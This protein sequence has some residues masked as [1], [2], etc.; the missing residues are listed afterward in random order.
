MTVYY[1]LYGVLLVTGLII[2]RKENKIELQKIK[3]RN[4]TIFACILLIALFALR[5]P[6]MGNDLG[7]G[8][9]YGYLGQFKYISEKS[10]ISVFTE[11]FLQYER[12]YI[13]LNKLIGIFTVDN[14]IFLLVIT[15]IALIPIFYYIYKNS[16]DVVLSTIIFMG[17]PVFEMYFSG[18]RQVIAIGIVALSIKYIE[19]KKLS[20]FILIIFIASLFHSSAWIFLIAYPIFYIKSTDLVKTFSTLALPIIYVLRY[21]LFEIFS[22]LFRENATP[23]DNGA[24][25]LFLVFTAVYIFLLI[26]SDENDT[27]QVGLRNLFWVACACQAF[28]GVYSIAMRVGYYFMMSLPILL[29]RV[30]AFQKKKSEIDKERDSSY[31][32]MYIIIFAA[33]VIFGLYTLK[34]GTWS[35][36]FPYYFY[37]QETIGG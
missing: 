24:I 35:K 29:P 12:A 33:F 23:D 20:K 5:H 34:V 18:L 7:Y 2:T 10:W 28:A 1:C 4:Y 15:A 31:V 37:W 26:F 32:L 19:S 8:Y 11:Q 16:D 25:M 9:F 6:S 30:L 3:N 27:V 36:S 22:S 21:Y 14:Q 13:L 17:I